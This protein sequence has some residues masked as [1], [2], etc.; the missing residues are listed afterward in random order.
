MQQVV[1]SITYR[2]QPKQRDEACMGTPTEHLFA[3][4]WKCLC[5]VSFAKAPCHDAFL[6]LMFGSCSALRSVGTWEPNRPDSDLFPE[7]VL[8][9][10]VSRG[11]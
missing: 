9:G 4:T 2:S 7:S 8:G 3:H 6:V 10:A 5:M 11:N 1:L